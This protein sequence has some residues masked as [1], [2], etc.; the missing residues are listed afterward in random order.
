MAFAVSSTVTGLFVGQV[1]MAGLWA[2][3][4]ALGVTI[5][6][7]LYPEAVGTASGLF[8]SAIT[9]GAAVGGLI[10]ALGVARLGLPEVFYLPAALSRVATV[11]LVVLQRRLPRASGPDHPLGTADRERADLGASRD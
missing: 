5:A 1:L 8:M 10:G 9:V 7:H 11:G 3:L 4:G 2:A 6:Q